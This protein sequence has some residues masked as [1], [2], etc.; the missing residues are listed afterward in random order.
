MAKSA[1]VIEE[2]IEEFKKEKDRLVVEKVHL[3][4]NILRLEDV[5]SDA[6]QHV[7][8]SMEELDALV[9][10]AWL[11]PVIQSCIMTMWTCRN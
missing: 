3:W 2:V 1:K 4:D 8:E 5:V 6:F 9:K 7:F 10:A 11:G